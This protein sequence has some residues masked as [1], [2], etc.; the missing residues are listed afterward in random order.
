[1][2]AGEMIIFVCF[3]SREFVVLGYIGFGLRLRAIAS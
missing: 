1:M 3:V 2:S